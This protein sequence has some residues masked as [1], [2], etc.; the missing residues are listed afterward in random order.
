MAT[1]VRLREIPIMNHPNPPFRFLVSACLCG[2]F[3]RYDG[4][5]NT[6]LE[7]AR[8]YARGL[9][10]P[11]CPEEAGG[12][13]TPREP[14][15]RLGHRVVSRTGQDMTT[16]FAAGATHTL[17]LARQYGLHIAI[18][19]ESSPSCGITTI[20][21]GTFTGTKILGM[22]L[23]ASLL[24]ENGLQLYSEKNIPPDLLKP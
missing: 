19:K 16:A 23:T 13:P 18:L 6:V 9:V 24:H 20:Y 7:L 11:V 10:L 8:L 4:K 3:C 2:F 22:G 15:E 14:C 5:A 21:D 12:L 17:A 1:P